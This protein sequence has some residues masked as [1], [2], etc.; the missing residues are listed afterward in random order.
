MFLSF[1]QFGLLDVTVVLQLVPNDL[2]I[3]RLPVQP[4]RMDIEY[5]PAIWSDCRS[6]PEINYPSMFD[7]IPQICLQCRPAHF[8]SPLL[9]ELMLFGFR[10]LRQK[11]SVV[12]VG[13]ATNPQEG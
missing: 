4:V 13:L 8:S 9:F 10:H 12:L 6:K 3:R 2:E 11:Q 7:R 5:D 1:R